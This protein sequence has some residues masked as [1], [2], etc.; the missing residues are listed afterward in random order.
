MPTWSRS[1]LSSK[2]PLNSQRGRTEPRKD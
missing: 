1:L 2:H